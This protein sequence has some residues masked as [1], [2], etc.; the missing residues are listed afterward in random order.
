V[1]LEGPEGPVSHLVCGGVYD[2]STGLIYRGG[3]YF[4]PT[5]GLW[6][7]LA[8]LVVVQSWRGRKQQKGWPWLSLW[9]LSLCLVS[10]LTA[11]RTEGTPTPKQLC[12]EMPTPGLPG[13]CTSMPTTGAEPPYEPER[14]NDCGII[15][16]SNNCYAYAA[17][18]PHDSPE[19]YLN[20]PQPGIA[21]GRQPLQQSEIT[22]TKVQ[23]A[24]IADG[25]KPANCDWPCG[26]GYYKVALVVDP[27]MDY[28][29][30]RQDR[31]GCWSGKPGSYPATNL[32]DSGMIISDPRLA[33]RN[34]EKY[35][36]NYRDFCGCFCVPQ[37]GIR[38]KCAGER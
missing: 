33:D 14:W 6:L 10:L 13:E 17:N 2:W 23:E 28:H 31:G 34:Y 19:C 20:F 16:F 15:Q 3:R 12:I 26:P 7:A 18:D 27:G 29:W 8:P 5:L 32:D 21:A 4:D 38:T 30:Y 36:L 22:C 1:V 11:C 37:S 25:F 9:L 24:A 35:N